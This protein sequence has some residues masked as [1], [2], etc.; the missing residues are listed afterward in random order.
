MTGKRMSKDE[1]ERWYSDR[2]LFG[3]RLRYYYEALLASHSC[4]V[5]NSM[6]QL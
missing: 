4:T 1:V 3:S 6:Q 5:G 2:E